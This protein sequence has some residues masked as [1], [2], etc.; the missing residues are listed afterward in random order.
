MSLAS[1]EPPE[2]CELTLEWFH[3][4]GLVRTVI[5]FLPT[6]ELPSARRAA[7][8]WFGQTPTAVPIQSPIFNFPHLTLYIREI[9][10]S[11]CTD[12]ELLPI[13]QL[14]PNLECL[15][16]NN[17]DIT[18]ETVHY[19]AQS[20]SLITLRLQYCISIVHGVEILAQC[21]TIRYLDLVAC[22]QLSQ[23]SLSY[24]PPA[25]RAVDLSN[26][27]FFSEEE[28]QEK[29][30]NL[31]RCKELRCVGLHNIDFFTQIGAQ[32]IRQCHLLHT[33]DLSGC[34]NISEEACHDLS[35]CKS[36]HTLLLNE[37]EDLSDT[38]VKHLAKCPV[39]HTLDLHD[40]KKITVATAY[41]LQECS[42]LHTVC[43][44]THLQEAFKTILPRCNVKCQFID[45]SV[46]SVC[47]YSDEVKK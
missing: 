22:Q 16:L 41:N 32:W 47:R 19:I 7:V 27:E 3:V 28:S 30:A 8:L 6:A 15:H 33:L 10:T 20:T 36:L 42:T 37:C 29:L 40:S 4:W 17:A 46:L 43:V 44:S 26:S 45:F 9:Y 11:N 21:K 18:D 12:K 23:D 1:S 38:A 2:P 34:D 14:C 5:R 25:L 24:L 13:L 35:T 31:A 39:L